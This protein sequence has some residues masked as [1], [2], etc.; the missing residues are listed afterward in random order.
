MSLVPALAIVMMA[1]AGPV[2][3]ANADQPN[4]NVNKAND[5]GGDTGNS[6]VEEL[7]RAQSDSSTPSAPAP[8][9]NPAPA[10]AK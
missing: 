7:N 5:K 1:A 6:R 2:L 10:P 9:A 4:T 8:A 3:A